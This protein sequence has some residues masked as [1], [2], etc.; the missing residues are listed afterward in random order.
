MLEG[1]PYQNYCLVREASND[2]AEGELLCWGKVE[3]KKRRQRMAP[4]PIIGGSG[5]FAAERED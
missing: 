2:N 5:D 1:I 3:G 4:E